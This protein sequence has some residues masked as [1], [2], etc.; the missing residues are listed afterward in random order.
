MAKLSL[1][2]IGNSVG[3]VL[4]ESLR[5]RMKIEAGDRVSLIETQSGWQLIPHVPEFERQMRAACSVTKT[6]RDALREL[7]N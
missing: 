4:P 6:Y 2:K 7:A 1:Q 5:A 3:I